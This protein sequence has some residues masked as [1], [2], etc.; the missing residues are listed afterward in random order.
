MIDKPGSR[1]SSHMYP[2]GSLDMPMD[3]SE[4]SSEDEVEAPTGPAGPTQEVRLSSRRRGGGT[5]R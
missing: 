2:H 1:M 4:G 3:G 5:L